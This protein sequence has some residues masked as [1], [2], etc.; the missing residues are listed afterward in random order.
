MP[1]YSYRRE[2]DTVF[3]VVQRITEDPL[4]HCPT[5][6]QRVR[7]IIV[8]PQVHFKGGGWASDGYSKR[9]IRK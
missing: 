2:D 4:I 5:T 9:K 6:G 7:R 1:T 3:E 8:A